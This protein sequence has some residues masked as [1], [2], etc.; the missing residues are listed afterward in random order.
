[1]AMKKYIVRTG[2]VVRQTLAK[3]DG[4][5]YDRDYNEGEELA[6][7]D[8]AAALHLHKLEFAGQKDRDAALAAEAAAKVTAAAGQDPAA[9]VQMLVA[10]LS[11]AQAGAAAATAAA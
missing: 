10:A 11:Q 8:D 1:M 2:F 4:S 9:L 7:E 5:T 6:L 3:A